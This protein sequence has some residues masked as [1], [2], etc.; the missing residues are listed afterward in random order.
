[1]YYRITDTISSGCLS[2]LNRLRLQHTPNPVLTAKA[3]DGKFKAGMNLLDSA[4]VR[5]SSPGS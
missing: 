2:C 4:R 1:M 5:M 3:L